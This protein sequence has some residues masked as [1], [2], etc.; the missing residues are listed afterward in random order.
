MMH[1][2]YLNVSTW[3]LP[4]S[5]PTATE[6]AKAAALPRQLVAMH[7]A[8]FGVVGTQAPLPL[9]LFQI[10]AIPVPMMSPSLIMCIRPT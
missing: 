7:A 5:E 10:R 6:K 8:R 2:R 1:Q 3:L 4:N 9:P